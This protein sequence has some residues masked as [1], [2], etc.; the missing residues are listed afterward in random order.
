MHFSH[1]LPVNSSS[2]I[3]YLAGFLLEN[4]LPR[5]FKVKHTSS[6]KSVYK[7][8]YATSGLF[9]LTLRHSKLMSCLRASVPASLYALHA[10]ITI[11]SRAHSSSLSPPICFLYCAGTHLQSHTHT[12]GQ[13]ALQR[14][15]SFPPWVVHA[16]STVALPNTI[17]VV[18]A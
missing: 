4:T 8:D 15:S 2:R 14:I 13:I 9:T 10:R 3:P 18:A 16:G 12:D 5:A 1:H 17:D 6:F 11:P 7:A